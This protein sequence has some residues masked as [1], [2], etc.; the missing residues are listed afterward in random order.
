MFNFSGI[1]TT[2]V[3]STSNS[4][5]AVSECAT[6]LSTAGNN[7][8]NVSTGDASRFAALLVGQMLPAF[9]L[10]APGDPGASPPEYVTVIMT[11]ST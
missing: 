9:F 5:T 10:L 7:Y 8:G 3:G 11:G 6:L 2:L 4:L 1:R